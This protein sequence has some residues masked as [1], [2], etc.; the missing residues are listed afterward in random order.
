[1]ADVTA[2]PLSARVVEIEASFG[3]GSAVRYQYG[4]GFRLGGRLVLTAAHVVT[5][6]AA[7]GIIVRG[8]DKVSR[9]ARVVDGAGRRSG[10]GGPAAA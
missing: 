2:V 9:P 10:H 4:S 3:T 1:M 6:D 5:G 8:L 7:A